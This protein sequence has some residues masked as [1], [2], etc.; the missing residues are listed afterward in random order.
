M[1]VVSRSGDADW[2]GAGKV[3]LFY[4]RRLL[5]ERCGGAAYPFRLRQAAPRSAQSLRRRRGPGHSGGEATGGCA[6][7]CHLVVTAMCGEAG[8]LVERSDTVDQAV[9]VVDAVDEV[10]AHVANTG[11]DDVSDRARPVA[12]EVID[13]RVG[14]A[15]VPVTAR[16]RQLI[17]NRDDPGEERR[18][19]AGA[20]KLVLV[21]PDGLRRVPELLGLPDEHAGADVTVQRDVRHDATVHIWRHALLVV[22]LVEEGAHAATRAIQEPAC[23]APDQV[24]VR[25]P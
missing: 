6:D 15:N 10:G 18:G 1:T 11:V 3:R 23:V 5:P 12:C 21:V 19:Q 20:T 14:E 2:S 8:V 22:G 16:V 7:T 13:R 4:S 17:G 24:A 9:R 25:V